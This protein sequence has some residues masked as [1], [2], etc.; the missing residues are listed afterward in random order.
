MDS[1]YKLVKKLI[2][3]LYTILL[4][5]LCATDQ[6]FLLCLVCFCQSLALHR[7]LLPFYYSVDV[8]LS[9]YKKHQVLFNIPCKLLLQKT[10]VY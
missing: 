4:N 6:T 10:G 2:S 3:Y 8:L 1:L 5:K 7:R 9:Y